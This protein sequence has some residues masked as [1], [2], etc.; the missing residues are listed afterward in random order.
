VLPP[1][2]PFASLRLLDAANSLSLP[3]IARR[4]PPTPHGAGM[5]RRVRDGGGTRS[6][7]LKTPTDTV[8]ARKSSARFARL[9]ALLRQ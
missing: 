2:P 3:N 5:R 8:G 4:P 9:T 7:A 6:P 1:H